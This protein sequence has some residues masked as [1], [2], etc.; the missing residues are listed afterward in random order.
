MKL[1]FLIIEAGGLTN[2]G[3]DIVQGKLQL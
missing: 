3:E 2:L 1:A